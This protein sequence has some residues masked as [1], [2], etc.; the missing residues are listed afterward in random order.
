MKNLLIFLTFITIIFTGCSQR[1]SVLNLDAYISNSQKLGFEKNIKI[2]SVIDNRSN[3]SIIAT[4]TDSSGKVDEYVML[5][6]DLAQW[7]E[8]GLKKELTKLGA[9]LNGY[10][11]DIV[12]DV[13]IVE[14]KA[15]L[16]GY[17]TDNLKGNVNFQI[18]VEKDNKTITK[19]IA[20]EQSKFAPIHTEGAF[21]SFFEELMQDIIKRVAI[22]IIKN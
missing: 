7:V 10:E 5:Q 14:L 19:N 15:N 9:N 16:S 13:K 17:S 22:Q 2:N 4:I 18:T 8:D 6:N 12:V 11:D 20:Q 3:K 21:K 1:S